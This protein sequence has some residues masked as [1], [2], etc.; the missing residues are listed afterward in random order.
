MNREWRINYYSEQVGMPFE[1]WLRQKYL[2]ERLSTNKIAVILYGDKAS[3]G[4]V[5]RWFKLFGIPLRSQ[6]EAIKGVMVGEKHPQYGKRGRLSPNYNPD[7]SDDEREESRKR[8]EYKDVVD[9]CFKRD[10]WTCQK[11]GSRG[12]N[13]NAHHIDNWKDNPD[14]RYDLDNLVTLCEGCHKKFH[15]TYGWRHTDWNKLHE[16]LEG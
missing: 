7:I 4:N 12:G 1:E 14:K 13:I 6:S 16:Y 9:K 3:S 15:S 8:P 10:N 5:V 2:D 11:C